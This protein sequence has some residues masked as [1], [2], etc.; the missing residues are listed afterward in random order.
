MKGRMNQKIKI[1]ASWTVLTLIIL[2]AC[3]A[4]APAVPLVSISD[5]IPSDAVKFTPEMDG[6]PPILHSEEWMQPVPLPG[7]LT[8]AG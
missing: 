7:V 2:V 1:L 6:T 8:T 4:P 5:A 3:Q